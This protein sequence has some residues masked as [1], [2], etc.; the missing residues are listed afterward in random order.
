MIN[1]NNTTGITFKR[2]TTSGPNVV[3]IHD[4]QTWTGP[5]DVLCS[6]YSM[7]NTTEGAWKAYKAVMQILLRSIHT[8][9]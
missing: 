5:Q 1:N 3:G 6:C 8:Y 4:R 7:K 2:I 9:Q